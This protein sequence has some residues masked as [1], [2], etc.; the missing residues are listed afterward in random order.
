MSGKADKA[1][2]RRLSRR[3]TI[4]LLLAILLLATFLRFWQLDTLPPGLYH[5]EAYNGL[6]ALSLI[7]G[8]TFPIFYEGWELYAQDAHATRPPTPTRFPLFFEGNYGRE[9]LHI[10]LMALSISLLGA[11][12]FAIRAV[13]AAAGVLAVLTTYLAATAIFNERQRP[14]PGAAAYATRLALLAALAMAILYPAVTFSRFG[15]RAMV[16]V[17][18][19]T[20]AIYCF[21]RGLAVAGEQESRKGGGMGWF[22]GG[23]FFLGLGLY[24]YAAGRLLPL[25][26]VG[27][28]LF[29]FWRDRQALRRY[30]PQVAVMA[31][32]AVLVAVPLLLFF[33]RYP[34]FFVFRIAYVANKGKGT[35]AGKPWLTW[36]GNLGRVFRGLFWLGETHLRH[37]LPG[38]PYLDGVQATFFLAGVFQTVRRRWPLRAFFLL[39]WLLVML[40][41][42]ILSGDAPHFGRM[43]GAAPAISILIALGATW[44]WQQVASRVSF[45]GRFLVALLTLFLFLASAALTVRDY[46]GRYAGHPQLP[47]KNGFYLHDWRLGQFAAAQPAESV[48]YL[49]PAQEEMATIYFALGGDFDRLRS[50]NGDEGVVPAG[51]PG[52]SIVYFVRP[53]A[54]QSLANL[55]AFFPDLLVGETQHNFLPVWVTAA[56]PRPQ[57]QHTAGHNWGNKIRLYG[58][59]LAQQEQRVTV[60]LYWQALAGMV[61]NYTAFVHLL[62]GSGPPVAQKDRSPAGYPTAAWQPGELVVDRYTIDL[63]ADFA[64]GEYTLQTGFYTLPAVEPLGE[65]AVLGKVVVR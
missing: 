40:L 9:P 53:A 58:W 35:V 43:T 45:S 2:G 52:A 39:L 47:G 37:N 60:T 24:V 16:F 8:A 33:A 62:D 10:Y 63:P 1:P 41:P 11:T 6:D 57:P 46:F 36:L 19:E 51:E 13:P 48:L 61:Q 32:T 29:W 27:F 4:P 31:T 55:Q 38:R 25:L 56:S 5:D 42:T 64:A 65:T 50:Y 12:P 34:Y 20:M 23:G 44:L 54:V 21:W 22:V 26:F 18:V 28:V 59:S 14:A 7:R 17:P 3:Q 15:L 30:W 49:T